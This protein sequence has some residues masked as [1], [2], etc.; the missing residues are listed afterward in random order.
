QAALIDDVGAGE[1][2]LQ[3]VDA[4]LQ[5]ALVLAG[6]VILGVLAEIPQVTG[7]RDPLGHLEHLAV[8]HAVEVGLELLI[9]FAGHGDSVGGH[10]LYHSFSQTSLA[11]GFSLP[12]GE[13]VTKWPDCERVAPLPAH[14]RTHRERPT[15]LPVQELS[16]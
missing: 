5:H 14:K 10:G 9:A 4:R 11:R 13:N 12:D 1:L 2:V 16:W 6:G 3:R 8:G 7:R 15:P